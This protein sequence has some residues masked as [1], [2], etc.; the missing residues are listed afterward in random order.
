MEQFIIVSVAAFS[1]A[2]ATLLLYITVRYF[3][4][5]KRYDAL[6]DADN[7]NRCQTLVIAMATA[8]VFTGIATLIVQVQQQ[9]DSIKDVTHTIANT[10]TTVT[11]TIYNNTVTVQGS[12]TQVTG[13]NATLHDLVVQDDSPLTPYVQSAVMQSNAYTD[14]KVASVS[15]ATMTGATNVSAGTNGSV[16]TPAAGDESKFLRGD[17]TWAH[18]VSYTGKSIITSASNTVSSSHSLWEFHDLRSVTLEDGSYPGQISIAGWTDVH[19]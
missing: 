19:D 14:E 17:A 5:T 8:M 15:V 18:A 13:T 12:T 9:N 2:A 6:H 3:S 10:T 11:H 16:P 7:A 4:S 1:A